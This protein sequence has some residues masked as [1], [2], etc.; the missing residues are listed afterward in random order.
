[1]LINYKVNYDLTSVKCTLVNYNIV[2]KIKYADKKKT[3]FR[4]SFVQ[5][6]LE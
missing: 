1:M 4:L 3:G 6:S 2:V 5:T